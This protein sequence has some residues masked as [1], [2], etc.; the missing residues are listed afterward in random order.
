[1]QCLAPL[2]SKSITVN[3]I[4]RFAAQIYTYHRVIFPELV[5]FQVMA[6]E[7]HNRTIKFGHI[8]TEVISSD[9]FIGC[10]RKNLSRWKRSQYISVKPVV[11]I[12]IITLNKR[13]L[14]VR[15]MR[16]ADLVAAHAVAVKNA[17]F[18]ILFPGHVIQ[19]LVS[20][21]ITDLQSDRS[22]K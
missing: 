8:Q 18:L 3:V 14:K 22:H 2:N 4:L 16:E 1:M 7:H 20:L 11:K 17:H 13:V 21:H 5:A 19:T 9:L 12:N 15:K 10:V 6:L